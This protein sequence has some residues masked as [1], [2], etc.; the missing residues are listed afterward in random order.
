MTEYQS[1]HEYTGN[2]SRTR[3]TISF[4]GGYIDP[5]HVK[6]VRGGV[7][8]TATIDAGE[9]VIS[10]AVPNGER[11]SIKRITPSG[12]ALVDFSDGAAI[13]EA[14]LDL[15]AKQS[16]FVAAEAADTTL[17]ATSR[18]LLV[19]DG[20][21]APAVGDLSNADGKLLRVEGD[22]IM[23]WG[24]EDVVEDYTA[25]QVA[26][27]AQHTA[28][29]TALN[30]AHTATVEAQK[31]AAA[32]S[33]TAAA[34]SASAAAGSA[35]TA[36]NKA[37]E[38]GGFAAAA[39]GHVTAANTA[40]GAAEAARDAALAAFDNFDD[41][42]LG[43]KASNPTVDNDGDPLQG[44][45]L[46]FNTTTKVMMLFDGTN[47]VAA[48]A[49]GTGF[50]S[51][52]GDTLTGGLA[53]PASTASVQPLVVP[54]GA[55]PTAPTNGSIWSKT[56][57]LFTRIAGVTKTLLMAG[58][59]AT[60]LNMATAR[61]LG[62]TTASAGAVEQISVGAGLL[63][64]GG[65]LSATS[66]TEPVSRLLADATTTSTS[67]TASGL[68]VTPAPDKAYEFVAHLLVT[69]S[70]SASTVCVGIAWPAGVVYG[71]A[72]IEACPGLSPNNT[73][74]TVANNNLAMYEVTNAANFLSGG[75]NFGSNIIRLVTVRGTLLTGA[76]VSGGLSIRFASS[77][78]GNTTSF[79]AGSFLRVK[80]L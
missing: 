63:L 76:T 21:T 79:K 77:S 14:N 34:G 60:S 11:F 55:D 73:S 37:N 4:A 3:W 46:Y 26:E 18:S 20:A 47:W 65:V 13:T 42:Y 80:E 53:L 70:N 56:T 29:I 75:M 27:N 66:T 69:G 17:N 41:V 71:H 7:P 8:A 1:I 22:A 54:H 48:Y 10:P 19:I 67:S 44:G 74:G 45:A 58:D 78:S 6:V 24:L 72:L 15:A 52:T 25:A 59:T 49:S 12:S 33:A 36:T 35:A 64:S 43:R 61:L 23:P 16:I 2:G 31:V 40:R 38:A 28:D 39:A 50:V 62:R 9:V 51:K 68:A 32:G 57:G 5:E 30:A